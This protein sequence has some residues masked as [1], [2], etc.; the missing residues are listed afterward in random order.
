MSVRRRATPAAY[1]AEP[2]LWLVVAYDNPGADPDRRTRFLDALTPILPAA[3]GLMVVEAVYSGADPLPDLGCRQLRVPCDEVLWQQ[4]RLLNLGFAEVP[5]GAEFIAWVSPGASL[6][7]PA[8]MRRAVER[9]LAGTRVVQLFD[10]V[11]PAAP[12]PAACPHC[13]PAG[14]FGWATHAGRLREHGLYDRS[15]TGDNAI[16]IAHAFAGQPISGCVTRRLGHGTLAHRDYQAWAALVPGDRM[17]ALPGSVVRVPAEVRRN[18]VHNEGRLVARRSRFDPAVDLE[19]N[20][21]GA[22]RFRAGRPDLVEWAA[23]YFTGQPIDGPDHGSVP[24]REREA[25]DFVKAGRYDEARAILEPQIEAGVAPSACLR[26]LGQMEARGG[27]W[28]QAAELYDEALA[29]LDA[30]YRTH[31]DLAEAMQALECDEWL[32]AAELAC[33]AADA[34]E[35]PG[36]SMAQDLTGT[37]DERYA[38]GRFE[39]AGALYD[40]LLRHHPDDDSIRAQLATCQ[41]YQGHARTALT[42][43]ESR[44]G[45]TAQDERSLL[46]RTQAY[47]DLGLVKPAV[48]V[49]RRLVAEVPPDAVTLRLL[50]TALERDGTLHEVDG[51]DQLVATQEPR[52]WFELSVRL[53]LLRHD[54][55]A[56]RRLYNPDRG[57]DV[58]AGDPVLRDEVVALTLRRDF[59][60]VERLLALVGR[61]RPDDVD[62]LIAVL[63]AAIARQDWDRAAGLVAHAER[64]W[65]S[66]LP[67]LLRVRQLTIDCVRLDV[68]AADARLQSWSEIPDL[69]WSIVAAL[70]A[71]QGRWDDVLALLHD[72]VDRG[73]DIRAPLFLESVTKA[74]RATSRYAEAIA[75]V[76]RALETWPTEHLLTFRDRLVAEAALAFSVGRSG[77]DPFGEEIR[78]PLIADRAARLARGLSRAPALA[79]DRTIYLCSDANY[80]PGTVVALFSLLRNNPGI[81]HRAKVQVVVSDDAVLLAEPVIE[82]IGTAYATSITIVPASL[83]A[84]ES[85]ELRTSWGSFTPTL[86]LSGAAYYRVFMVMHLLA[87]GAGGRALYI[88]SDTCVGGGIQRLLDSD[89]AGMPLGTRRE[90]DLPEIL[91]AA[92]R[93]DVPPESYFNSGVLLFDL[94]HPDLPAAVAHALDFAAHKPELLT[95]VDQCALNVAFLGRTAELPPECNFYL[96]QEDP[97]PSPLLEPTILHFLARPKPW[98]PAYRTDNCRPWLREFELLSQ[99]VDPADL[100]A[101]MAGIFPA[102][103]PTDQVG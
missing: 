46:V 84:A 34:L 85:V 59:T 33:F 22:W 78:S 102:T 94:A 2:R 18:R 10:Q 15:L 3:G 20:S 39:E 58:D 76:D 54:D 11:E 27:N 8:W 49:L 40:Y 12:G 9:L 14:A 56:L 50:L 90:L 79:G 51:L 103:G 81:G 63:D 61:A 62:L 29:C 80:L 95:F 65:S 68:D 28:A 4:E 89:L 70:Q 41:L 53:A 5:P 52:E 57:F 69:A 43:V 87:S 7:D 101:V 32:P 88:D 77:W 6:D 35:P 31:L 91:A 19:L 99:V 37:A 64:T 98:D 26:L 44:P 17:A 42:T 67:A 23:S 97:P 16:L 66:P 93:L 60:R 24:D 55:E 13:Q 72:G 45:G 74:V 30:D 73:L 36:R 86:G 75:V 100:R 82:A 83:I 92:A 38:A 96:R 48:A 71:V 21:D 25:A 1:L 47:L